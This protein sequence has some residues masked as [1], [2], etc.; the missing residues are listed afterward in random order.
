MIKKISISYPALESDKWVPLLS[1][2]RQF[3]W[4]AWDPTF[5]FPV[6]PA[7]A[8]TL[9]KHNWYEVF[10]DDWIAE[11]LSYEQWLNRIIT[12]AP[13]LIAIETKTPTVRQIW[14]IINELKT[15]LPNS[16]IVLMWD[17]ATAFPEES[18]EYSNVDYVMATWDFDF[19]LLDLVKFLNWEQELRAW[20]Y[21]KDWYEVKNSWKWNVRKKEYDLNSLPHIDRDLVKY[22]LYAYKNWNFK[23]EPGTYTMVW[24]DCWWWKCTFC[25]WTTYYPNWTFRMQ[26]PEYLIEELE[27]NIIPLWIKEV[28]DDSWT[29]PIGPWLRKFCQLM[30]DKWLN[31]KITMWCNM[32]FGY[33]KKEDYELMAK[34]NFRFVLYGIESANQTTLDKLDKW[35]DISVVEQELKYLREANKKHNGQIA[36]HITTMIWY[37]WETYEE[38][39]NTIDFCRDLF[40]KWLLDTLQATIVMPYPWTPLYNQAIENDWLMINPWDWDRYDMRERVLKCPMSESEVKWLVQSIY[41]SF[42]SPKFIIRKIAG[43]RSPKDVMFLAKAWVKL[44]NHLIDF[45]K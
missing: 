40:S 31:K 6:I 20:W 35:L 33:L 26:S 42:V 45:K 12:E 27:K 11:K 14:T 10:W 29:F 8:A 23:Y 4:F 39:K 1:Q 21:W 9:L 32:R 13:D 43:I 7:Y 5:I 17:H 16:K 2:N 3:Q 44:L 41:K 25:S 38:A 15:K 18:F 24:R 22:E 34:A 37:P 36:P 19:A 30:I 28:F